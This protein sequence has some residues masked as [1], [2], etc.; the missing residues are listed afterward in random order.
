MS[1]VGMLTT[2]SF[3]SSIRA[4]ECLSGQMLTATR[5]GLI[6]AGIAQA[7]VIMFGLLVFPMQETSTVCIG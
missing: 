7:K 1:I 5:C 6:D 4:K 2:N 3:V